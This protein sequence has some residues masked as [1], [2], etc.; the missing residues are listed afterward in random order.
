MD[1]LHLKGSLTLILPKPSNTARPHGD[2]AAVIQ[3]QTIAPYTSSSQ[4]TVLALSEDPV[5]AS[6]PES[7]A[8]RHILSYSE[9]VAGD[10]SAGLIATAD[11][12]VDTSASYLN[13]DAD[14]TDNGE[15]QSDSHVVRGMLILII[16]LSVVGFVVLASVVLCICLC[17]RRRA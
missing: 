15:Y 1:L 16:V 12:I 8:I 6:D 13:V 3:V 17:C 10:A 5:Y 14:Q 9:V 11:V 2:I 7:D 4:D